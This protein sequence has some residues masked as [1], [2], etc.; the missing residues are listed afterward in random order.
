MDI[1]ALGGLGADKRTFTFINLKNHNLI[2]LDWL[3]PKHDDMLVSYAAR[4][5]EQINESKDFMLVGVSFGG[6][7]MTEVSKLKK[8]NHLVLISSVATH[9]EL[10]W[11]FRKAARLNIDRIIPYGLMVY[12]GKLIHYMSGVQLRRDK[13]LLTE[14]MEDTSSEFVSWSVKVILRWYNPVKPECVRI[15][16]LKDRVLPVKRSMIDYPIENTGHFAI[17]NEADYIS[18]VLDLLT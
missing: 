17:V 18:E 12:S 10:R 11:I 8:P 4:I 15:H 14:I 6:M 7:I 9:T 13:K 3:E 1:Y 5:S 16:G 2:C